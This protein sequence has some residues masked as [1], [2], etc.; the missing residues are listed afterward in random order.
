MTESDAL[1]ILNLRPGCSVEQ[2]RQAYLDLV[3]VWHPDRFHSDGRLT[4]RA[5]RELQEINEAYDM[6]QSR[7]TSPSESSSPPPLPKVADARSTYS[8]PASFTPAS[9]TVAAS[10]SLAKTIAMG[11]GLGLV[12]ATAATLVVLMKGGG[13]SAST[14]AQP[15]AAVTP[16]ASSPGRSRAPAERV[17]V[18][19]RQRPESGTEL[20]ALRRSGGGSLVLNNASERDAVVALTTTS[21]RERAVYVRAG[22]QVT[23]LNVATGTYRVQM[24]VGRD[25]ASDR[26]TR[27]VG[28]QELEEP[29]QFLETTDGN[30]TEFTKLTVSLQPIVAGMHGIRT[31]RPFRITPQ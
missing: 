20:L 5:E 30:T 28:Y 6:L 17:A 7:M 24:M 18:A 14:S 4:A 21:G 16:P 13:R 15:A 25:W 8:E 31:A 9:E 29:V 22:E 1:R 27:E 19:S 26:F 23:I 11:I 3:K 2:L 12:I 10:P